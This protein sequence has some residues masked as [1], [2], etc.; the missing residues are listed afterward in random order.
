[1]RVVFLEVLDH[2]G[3]GRFLLADGDVDAF[4]AGVLLA[5]DRIDA[6]RGLP[7]LAVADDQFAL[8]PA[9]GRHRVDRLEARVHRFVDRLAEDDPGGD[10]LD[11]AEFRRFDGTL[12]V[13]GGARGVDDAAEHRFADG[14]LGDLPGPLH[15]VAF[16]DMGNLAEHGHADVVRLEVQD[17][18]ENPSGEFEQ[19][20]G[21]GVLHAV[22]P[23]DAVAD[24]E[25]RSRF[26]DI[27]F[28]LVFLDLPG[29]D[30]AD[31]LC[32]DRFHALLF[33]PQE[34]PDIVQLRLDAAVVERIPDPDDD[35]PEEGWVF[36][37]VHLDLPAGQLLQL[38]LQPGGELAGQR[39]SRRHASP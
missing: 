24:G 5:D 31:F 22:D 15:D 37:D 36:N 3:D 18:A 29:Y 19:L 7:D 30:L 17:H 11:P 32:P 20:H 10:H 21:H 16:L 28:F 1:M 34:I 2:L 39:K 8:P 9:D 12:A 25:D 33:L 26:A 23:G 6:D 38:R 14:D 13:Q 35:A 27:Q 4:H